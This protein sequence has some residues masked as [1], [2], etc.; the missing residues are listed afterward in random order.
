MLIRCE[1]RTFSVLEQ[2]S[3]SFSLVPNCLASIVFVETELSAG[4]KWI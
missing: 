2:F 4:P 1:K 3:A